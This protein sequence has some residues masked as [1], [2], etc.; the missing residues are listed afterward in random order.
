VAEYGGPQDLGG[1]SGHRGFTGARK[2]GDQHQRRS[3]LITIIGFVGHLNRMP[4]L[5]HRNKSARPCPVVPTSLSRDS[6]LRA[7]GGRSRPVAFSLWEVPES[8]R[9]VDLVGWDGPWDEDD[10]DAN[11]KSDV[12][13]YAHVDPMATI[14]NLAAAMGLPEGAVVHYVLAK[15]ASAGSGGLLELGPSMVHRLWAVVAEAEEEGTSAARLVAYEQ[16]R[17]MISWLRLPLIDDGADA[18]Y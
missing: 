9:R 14:S 7:A 3:P 10:P 2:P 5:G 12:A 1:C 6:L 15:W 8:S 16:L 18:G 13:L 11:F 17:Q 4:Y